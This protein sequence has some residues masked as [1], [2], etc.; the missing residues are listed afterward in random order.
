MN[1]F[2]GFGLV[3]NLYEETSLRETRLLYRAEV[4]SIQMRVF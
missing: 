1:L 2:S 4:F 3:Q